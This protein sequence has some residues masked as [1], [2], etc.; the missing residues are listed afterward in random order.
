MTKKCE[1]CSCVKGVSRRDSSGASVKV[2]I[3]FS[4]YIQKTDILQNETLNT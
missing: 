2:P 4:V 3:H 1:R